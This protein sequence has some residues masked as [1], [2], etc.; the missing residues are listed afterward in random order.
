MLDFIIQFNFT[1]IPIWFEPSLSYLWPVGTLTIEQVLSAQLNCHGPIW[2]SLSEFPINI[3]VKK[4]VGG[5]STFCHN[6][7][8]FIFLLVDKSKRVN[9]HIH[10]YI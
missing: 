5:A 3:L 10:I 6:V 9:Q 4:N 1:S 8:Y 2:P 7:F